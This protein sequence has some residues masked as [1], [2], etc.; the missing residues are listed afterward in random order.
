MQIRLA[1]LNDAH[2]IARVHVSS[3][4]GAYR[5]ILPVEYLDSVSV[6][7]REAMWREAIAR[8]TPEVWVIKTEAALAG[9]IAFGPC[10][11]PDMFPS[12]A[13]VWA[14][15]LSPSHWSLGYG[16]RLWLQARE[17]LIQ[18]QYRRVS[19]WV[20]ADNARAIRFYRAAG[21][22]PEILSSKPCELGDRTLH[23]LRWSV[24][25]TG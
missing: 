12:Q 16:R 24:E 5:H 14:L 22:T 25:L 19:L 6:A 10:R 3:W 8:G 23:E 18:Q 13:E 11:D 17:R 15:Y 7:P 21:F 20:L 1:T 2:D 9:F 4:Q